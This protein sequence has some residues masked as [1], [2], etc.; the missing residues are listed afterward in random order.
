TDAT[1]LDELALGVSDEFPEALARS[2]GPHFV[3]QAKGGAWSRTRTAILAAEAG[4][5]SWSAIETNTPLVAEA[6][7]GAIV[8]HARSREQGEPIELPALVGL[9]NQL[10]AVPT[11]DSAFAAYLWR[12][13][14][15]I[16]NPD[17]RQR[18]AL[19]ARLHHHL[20]VADALTQ[21]QAQT[22]PV[23]FSAWRSKA[24]PPP[25]WS[26]G[27]TVPEG[28]VPAARAW[29]DAR[30]APPWD[31][32]AAT[33]EL[34]DGRATPLGHPNA[35]RPGA[36]FRLRRLDTLRADTELHL[37]SPD[38]PSLRVAAGAYLTLDRLADHLDDAGRREMTNLVDR[39]AAGDATADARVEALLPLAHEA[40]RARLRAHPDDPGAAKLRMWLIVFDE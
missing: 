2:P 28:L 23:T 1:T 3:W 13:A 29:F 18:T 8:D 36:K 25:G 26:P 12:C 11:Y 22:A 34:V 19:F 40:I 35:L 10:E 7:H 5:V 31:R 6:L 21:A 15:S 4:R 33:L 38:G 16:A 32:V 37:A 24:A 30:H 27:A 17:L 39:A 14:R 9:L 20:R